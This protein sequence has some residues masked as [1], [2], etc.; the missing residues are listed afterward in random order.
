MG[1][2]DKRL[3]YITVK[4]FI[5]F[6]SIYIILY[7]LVSPLIHSAF[8]RDLYIICSALA[9]TLSLAILNLTLGR[10]QLLDIK[11]NRFEDI[12]KVIRFEDMRPSNI[13]IVGATGSG[14]TSFIK[15]LLLKDSY[16]L[17]TLD[18]SYY[19]SSSHIIE[20]AV[21]DPLSSYLISR[22]GLKKIAGIIRDSIGLT[23]LQYLKLLK[24]MKYLDKKGRLSIGD[25][26]SYIRQSYYKEKDSDI[27]LHYRY[28]LE[29]LE[30]LNEAYSLIDDID[31]ILSNNTVIKIDKL[32]QQEI[33]LLLNM[34]LLL[35]RSSRRKSVI[36]D[37]FGLIAS[38][39]N[40]S[41]IEKLYRDSRK[42]SIRVVVST[43]E[44][45]DLSKVAIDNSR[46][47]IFARYQIDDYK[48]LRY[49]ISKSYA[50]IIRKLSDME[51][52]IIDR[53]SDRAYLYSLKRKRDIS[54]AAYNSN[55]SVDRVDP[56]VYRF[57]VYLYYASSIKRAEELLIKNKLISRASLYGDKRN[58]SIL[59]KA[60][61]LGYIENSKLSYKALSIVDPSIIIM[62]QGL[63]S[64]GE[65][66]KA[67]MHKLI[68]YEQLRGNLIVSGSGDSPDL[69]VYR[70]LDNKSWEDKPYKVYEVQTNT[71]ESEIKRALERADRMH[72]KPIFVLPNEELLEN[73]ISRYNVD[74]ICIDSID[75]YDI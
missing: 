18:D 3:Y 70:S 39:S 36:I 13:F 21:I 34:I 22:Y 38:S 59:E 53:L 6:T 55:N 61:A 28:M 31:G 73:L 37:D 24:A 4:R 12:D 41:I 20:N 69:L 30:L 40:L 56:L 11:D 16:I 57:L 46:Y 72:Y 1:L 42:Y 49:N 50:N 45:E 54:N 74:A 68:R 26:I 47:L 2:L 60:T 63:L 5:V 48:A 43:Q 32:N 10:E 52:L 29:R 15:E 33:D 8:Y 75:D 44:L 71:R 27:K 25:L 58:L 62:R 64:G 14:K 35:T 51:Y 9:L 19:S 23:E 67:M 66:H 65:L 7:L 17:I